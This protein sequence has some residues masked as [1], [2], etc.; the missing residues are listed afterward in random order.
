[1]YAVG[2]IG[3]EAQ[4][5]PGNALR[6]R[7]FDAFNKSIPCRMIFCTRQLDVSAAQIKGSDGYAGASVPENSP[8]SV[9]SRLDPAGT[10]PR[11]DASK[12]V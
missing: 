4:V 2:I 9:W 8:N 11:A 7:A 1:M 3:T 6:F 10:K 5:A 12:R